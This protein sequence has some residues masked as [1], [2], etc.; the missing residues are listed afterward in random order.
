MERLTNIQC[1]RFFA[2]FLVVCYHTRGHYSFSGGEWLFDFAQIGWL[3]VD[4][5]FVISGYI[6]WH[7]TIGKAGFYES[8]AF[9]YKRFSRVFSGFLPWLVIMIALI[10]YF[11]PQRLHSQ[12]DLLS[13]FL[14][15][16]QPHQ[17]N[18]FAVS[19]TLS[20]EL[21]FYTGF[22][23]VLLLPRN[24]S[25]KILVGLSALVCLGVYLAGA[26]TFIFSPLILEFIGGALLAAYVNKYGTKFH[27][28][29]IF[30]TAILFTIGGLFVDEGDRI[31]RILTIGLGSIF[32]V[33][34]FVSL[35]NNGILLP[36]LFTILG[37]ASYALYLCHIPF[38]TIIRWTAR[39]SFS[40]A[41]ELCYAA[42]VVL[43]IVFSVLWYRAYEKPVYLALVGQLKSNK[44]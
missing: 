33:Y 42:L 32:L 16:P 9:I 5:F 40:V 36:K 13:S 2:A 8:M 41:P 43:M 3:G 31:N 15:I 10:G 7:T 22:A 39:E 6:M 14:L 27:L 17:T 19:W 18:I 11:I 35:E 29:A 44:N 23:F 34:F 26:G 38:L 25:I 28:L 30:M 24:W 21:L 1:L 12:Y 4:I 37:D 20:F